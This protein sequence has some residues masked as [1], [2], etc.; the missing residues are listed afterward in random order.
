MIYFNT[1]Y[2]CEVAMVVTSPRDCFGLGLPDVVDGSCRLG[3][4][5]INDSNLHDIGHSIELTSAAA[6]ADD[7]PTMPTQAPTAY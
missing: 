6:K 1:V 7:L 4:V 2:R 3:P 5:T